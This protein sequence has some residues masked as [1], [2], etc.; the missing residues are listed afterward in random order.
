MSVINHL[1]WRHLVKYAN[2]LTIPIYR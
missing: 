2:G 1:D